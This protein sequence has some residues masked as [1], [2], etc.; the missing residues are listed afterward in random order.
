MKVRSAIKKMCPDCY[1]VRRGKVRF[2]YCKTTPKHK[3]RQGFHSFARDAESSWGGGF[4]ALC[5]PAQSFSTSLS[6][7]T[8]RLAGEA[9]AASSPKNV[10]RRS[11][12]SASSER[13]SSDEASSLVSSYRAGGIFGVLSRAWGPSSIGHR[14]G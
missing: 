6:L 10:V 2:V 14:E 5:A 9:A 1:I 12:S 4:C 8:L 3:Q 13:G 11:M 7:G